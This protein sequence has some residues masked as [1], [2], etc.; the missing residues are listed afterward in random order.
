MKLPPMT[1]LAA[2]LIVKLAGCTSYRFQV[3]AVSSQTVAT[4]ALSYR[5][6][7]AN[8]EIDESD[9]RYLEAVAYLK[10]ALSA[11]GMYEAPDGT[12]PDLVIEFDFGMEPRQDVLRAVNRPSMVMAATPDQPAAVGGV[13]GRERGRRD[14]RAHLPLTDALAS[15]PVRVMKVTSYPKYLRITARETGESDDDQVQ[16]EAWSV[17]VSNADGDDD[18]RKYVPLM[19]SAAMDSLNDQTEQ[20]HVVVLTPDDERVAFVRSVE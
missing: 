8:P 3:D 16:R 18:L 20:D 6:I 12:E 1:L 2:L 5:V 13:V 15:G 4:D 19:V 9:L 11:K 17:F 14:M 10:T 7:N